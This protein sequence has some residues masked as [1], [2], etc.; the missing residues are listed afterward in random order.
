M[1]GTCLWF[2]HLALVCAVFLW[3]TGAAVAADEGQRTWTGQEAVEILE[4]IAAGY[5]ANRPREGQLH[6]SGRLYWEQHAEEGREIPPEKV[7]EGQ[8]VDFDY[9]ESE[10]KRRYEEEV[11]LPKG[12][13]KYVL[14]DNEKIAVF[15]VNT[16]GLYPI[17]NEEDSWVTKTGILGD[18]QRVIRSS[19][20]NNVAR[21][22]RNFGKYFLGDKAEAGG[23][24]TVT[25]DEGVY[26]VKYMSEHY[27]L[28]TVID[29][30]KGF[31]LVEVTSISTHPRIDVRYKME[32]QYDQDST[33]EWV[34]ARVLR[35]GVERGVA[36]TKELEVTEMG[37]GDLGLSDEIFEVESLDIPRDVYIDDYRFSPPLSFKRGS[38]PDLSNVEELVDADIDVTEVATID[39]EGEVGVS[40]HEAF[41]EHQQEADNGPADA[42]APAAESAGYAWLVI[43]ALAAVVAVGLLMVLRRRS[44]GG[45]RE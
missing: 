36:F 5:E 18:S 21:A 44:G 29:S 2:G 14:D 40:D 15:A 28:E 45:G 32:C 35:T 38:V 9:Y 31:N 13:R 19:E 22:M 33:G 27:S 43:L 6:L 34:L 17:E 42:A 16:L 41:V 8:W 30:R 10:G 3:L 12:K 39:G 37:S 25:E 23:T 11:R 1:K 24:F 26:R 7:K 20:F 4:H